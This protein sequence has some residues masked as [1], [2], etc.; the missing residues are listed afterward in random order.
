MEQAAAADTAED[1]EAAAAAAAPTNGEDSS[2]SYTYSSTANHSCKNR[3]QGSMKQ[4]HDHTPQKEFSVGAS[5]DLDASYIASQR[6]LTLAGVKL[7]QHTLQRTVQLP[8]GGVR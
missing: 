5:S 7:R 8:P 2:C 6:M 4:R 3:T 1:D